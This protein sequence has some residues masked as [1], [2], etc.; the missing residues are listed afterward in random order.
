ML[1]TG[2]PGGLVM[3]L[4]HRNASPDVHGDG[5]F[6]LIT[7]DTEGD[8]MWSRPR[9][10]ETRNAA[11]LPR[12]QG[13]CEKYGFTPTYLTNYEMARSPV[14]REL[15]LDVLRRNAG[16][17]GMHLHAWHSPPD[18]SLTADD[19]LH[20][21][22][23]I[24]Y[25]PDVMRSKIWCLTDILEETFGV[26]MV[27][28]R[29]GRWSFTAA[30]AR[31]LVERG[32]R[33]D[34]SVTP[35]VSWRWKQGDPRGPGGTDFSRFPDFAYFVDLDD[36]SRP[37]DSELLEVP[38]TILPS[39]PPAVRWLARNFLPSTRLVAT[40]L[41]IMLPRRWLRPNGRNL[42]QLL[43]IVDEAVA[44]KR[45]YIEFVLHSSEL[46]PGGSSAFRT[47]QSVESLYEHLEMLFERAARHFS[48]ATLS[49][50]YRCVRE[51]QPG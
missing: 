41:S 40:A 47:E 45:R 19:Y 31:L 32:Y 4:A 18:H 13:L 20:H 34:C 8:S 35:H 3:P 51:R 6:L 11:F 49:Q 25:P 1:T 37:G 22:F 12:F 2:R 33:V 30:Y 43:R 21:P 23:L 16:E 50:F 38:V 27:S 42:N 28:H 5:P 24:D 14:F 7:I 48:G 46:M 10:I 9:T 44:Q 36:L 39:A 26:K 15:G 29:S 17:I